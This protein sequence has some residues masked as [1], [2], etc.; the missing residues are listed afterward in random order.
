MKKVKVA[1][2]GLG[3]VAQII[4][5]PIL[6][7]LADR[8]EIVSICDISGKL[9]QAIG[10]RYTI[11]DRYTDA[12]EMMRRTEAEAVFVLNSDEYHAECSVLALRHGKHVFIE[13]PV[14]LCLEDAEAIIRAKEEAGTEVMVG[15]MRRFA[16]AYTEA[17]EDVRTMGKINYARIRAM[18]GP[19][20][21]FIDD[22]SRVLLPDD[23]AE[24][25]VRDRAQRA[26][27][28]VRQALGDAPVEHQSAYRHMCGLSS[29]DLSAM[30]ELIGFPRRVAAAASWN[31]GR[32]MT[33]L[34]EFDGYYATFETG[35]DH[36]RRF[37]AHLQVYGESKAVTVQYD[38]PYIR[39]LPTTK[40]VEETVGTSFSRSVVSPTFKDPYT[41][42]LEYFHQVVTEGA[43]PKTTVEDSMEDLR[44]FRMIVEA[45]PATR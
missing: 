17:V 11:A 3:S 41:V 24:E 6:E 35:V 26:R 4:H 32:Y 15:Y 44:L 37:D 21:F 12:A 8:Y 31:G 45:L 2:V 40:I 19:N 5:L 23:I 22:T 10:D 9:L 43:K 42:E 13:K 29:H 38:T 1:I 27:Q 33:A 28:M 30:R 20:R 25:H 14:C 7:M 39:H 18:I 34:F 16:P 36:N